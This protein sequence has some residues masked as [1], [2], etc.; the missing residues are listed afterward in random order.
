MCNTEYPNFAWIVNP[1]AR[2]FLIEARRVARVH[3]NTWIFHSR[4]LL[5]KF[6]EDLKCPDFQRNHIQFCSSKVKEHA[7]V[8]DNV[9]STSQQHNS[10]VAAGN[11]SLCGHM[12][13]IRILGL[14]GRPD[15][16]LYHAAFKNYLYNLN[17]TLMATV[18]QGLLAP[19]SVT[20]TPV[21]VKGF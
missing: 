4:E 18:A 13:Q 10:M 2:L 1:Q 19:P 17:L 3:R 6:G 12:V 21:A 11:A 16:C 9:T 15:L 7:F 5:P 8:T 20:G 14:Y